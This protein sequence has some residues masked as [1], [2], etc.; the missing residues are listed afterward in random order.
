MD[1][2]IGNALGD[3]IIGSCDEKSRTER[4]VFHGLMVPLVQRDDEVARWAVET[5]QRRTL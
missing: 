5:E 3:R 4:M 2:V 1:G